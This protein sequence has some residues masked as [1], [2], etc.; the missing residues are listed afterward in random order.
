MGLNII[1]IIITN[2]FKYQTS[3]KFFN[4]S[5]NFLHSSFF[6][7]TKT[8]SYTL[9]LPSAVL[10]RVRPTGSRTNGSILLL[11]SSSSTEEVWDCVECKEWNEVRYTEENWL[12]KYIKINGVRD[13]EEEKQISDENADEMHFTYKNLRKPNVLA[14]INANHC[15]LSETKKN[16]VRGG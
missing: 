11:C 13:E 10:L 7:N 4:R 5:K 9:E 15:K 8:S 12:S 14:V 16:K 6:M 2:I 1:I 3:S